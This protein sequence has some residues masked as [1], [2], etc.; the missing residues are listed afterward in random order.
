MDIDPQLQE[1]LMLY[2][3][4]IPGAI[5]LL[6]MMSVWY[7]HAFLKAKAGEDAHGEDPE[8]KGASVGPRWALPILLAIGFAGADYA[9]NEV[10]HL[11]PDSNSY[12]F[13]HAIVLITLAALTEGLF[14]IPLLLGFVIR[15]VAYCGAFWMLAEGYETSVFGD[16]AALIGWTL[17]AG[18]VASLVSI[19]SDRASED[20][21]G[22]ADS[23]VWLVIAGAMMPILLLNHF[24]IGAMVPA[25]IIAVLVSTLIASLIFRDIRL[26]R[27]G[28]TVL[29]GLML[30]MLTGSVVQTGVENLPAVMLLAA[31]PLVTLVPMKGVAGM[32]QLLAR[33]ILLAVVLGSSGGLMYASH[34]ADGDEDEVD[35][36]ADYLE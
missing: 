27:G 11:W 23:I 24:S 13:T 35:P 21:P 12:R 8:T 28:V 3:G 2:G 17:F 22:W 33:L 25:G 19:A 31:S 18:I 20:T 5:A 4:L 7:A 10:L 36:Y 16:S 9:S 34:S 29:V 6:V 32:R 14:T 15:M 26:S 30:A 1:R